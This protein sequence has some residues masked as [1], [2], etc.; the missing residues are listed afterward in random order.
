[1]LYHYYRYL[2]QYPR[3]LYFKHLLVEYNK[4]FNGQLEEWVA[5]GGPE[6]LVGQ[7]LEISKR[8]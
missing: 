3:L 4:L 6:I 7:A 1:V 2:S 8:R 5:E